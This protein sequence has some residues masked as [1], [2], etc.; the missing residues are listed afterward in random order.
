MKLSRLIIK[1]FRNFESVDVPMGQHTVIVGENATGK[2]NLLAAIRLL[3]DPSLPERSRM[4]RAEDFWEG[5][6]DPITNAHTIEVSVELQDFSDNKRALA[7]LADC[8]VNAEPLTARISYLFGPLL[9]PDDPP[10]SLDDY[11]YVIYGGDNRDLPLG[12]NLRRFVVMELLPALRDAEGDLSG[13]RRSPLRPLIQAAQ[14]AI[15]SRDPDLIPNVAKSMETAFGDVTSIDEIAQ[16]IGTI[17]SRLVALV[18]DDHA[19]DA[20]LDI[21]STDPARLLRSLQLVFD[22]EAKRTIS[23][24]S[25]GASNTLYVALR[26]LGLEAAEDERT[27]TFLAIEEP[28]AH[29]HPQLQRVMYRSLLRDSAGNADIQSLLLTTHSPHIASVAPIRSILLLRHTGTASVVRSG[30]Q[31]GLDECDVHDIERYLD[32]TRAEL[33]FAKRVLF[34]EGD[35]ERFLLPAFAREL[36]IDFDRIGVSV[37]SIGG[38]HFEPFVKLVA[39]SALDIPF[40][41]LT[42]RDPRP[43]KA[44]L[45]VPRVKRLLR[46]LDDPHGALQHGADTDTFAA[47]VRQTGIFVGIHTLEFDIM[48]KQSGR[49]EMATT[50]RSFARGEHCNKLATQLADLEI[51]PDEE[52][53]NKILKIIE[54]IGK[55]RFAQ[56]LAGQIT[57]ETCPEYIADA[58]RFIAKI[59]ES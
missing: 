42:D 26:L 16:L 1:N 51:A 14:D 32:V 39:P 25:L 57:T 11:E 28:E 12:Y 41:V 19:V 22:G 38:T 58:I 49:Q 6:N 29:V 53:A 13:W 48:G 2:S 37:C 44:P 35:A 15:A 55:G 8:I 56:R 31:A 3:L 21:A 47:A 33:L 27:H 17:Q 20:T 45:A 7:V 52:F 40:A 36:G 18:G 59:D 23:E 10:K 43:G 4:L 5:L 24:A 46:I 54:K 50:L 30:A 34:V 9:D